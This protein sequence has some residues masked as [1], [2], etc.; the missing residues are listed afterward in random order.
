MTPAQQSAR[1]EQR[2]AL[3]RELQLPAAVLTPALSALAR[4]AAR[5]CACPVGAVSIVDEHHQW[6]VASSGARTL[7][8]PR[9]QSF[10]AHALDKDSLFEVEDVAAD[11]RFAD[12]PMLAAAPPTRYFAGM[13][14]RVEGLVLGTVSVVDSTPGSA[15]TCSSW[16]SRH[17]RCSSRACAR[18]ASMCWT[19]AC[20]WPARP[21]ATGC[22]S[23][24][25]TAC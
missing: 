3:L 12:H 5:L 9:A 25:R 14:I 20:A 7:Q 21:A 2:L 22:G 6:M 15:R 13:P 24:T 4:L 18:C 8:Q 23:P 17:P 19:S 10:S 1:E 16:P 11:P